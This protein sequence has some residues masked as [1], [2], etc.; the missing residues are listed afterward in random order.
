MGWSLELETIDGHF[1]SDV[2]ARVARNDPAILEETSP[3]LV[4]VAGNCP[5]QQLLIPNCGSCSHAIEEHR[6][7]NKAVK[8]AGCEGNVTTE[9]TGGVV[10]GTYVIRRPLAVFSLEHNA[11]TPGGV[12]VRMNAALPELRMISPDDESE[13]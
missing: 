12:T 8:E 13:D 4:R 3:C 7:V 9:T 11:R 2:I 1:V 10:I 6:K 5:N